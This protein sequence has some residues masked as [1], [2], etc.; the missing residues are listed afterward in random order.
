MEH[1]TYSMSHGHRHFSLQKNLEVYDYSFKIN[2][3]K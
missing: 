3:D 1:T 2:K